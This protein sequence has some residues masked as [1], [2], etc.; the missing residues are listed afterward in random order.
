MNAEKLLET[1]SM[2]NREKGRTIMLLTVLGTSGPWPK[3]GGACSGYLLSHQNRHL[4]L[5]MGSG[6]LSRLQGYAPPESLD[7]IL[8]SHWHFDHAG[9]L[10][11]FVYWQAQSGYRVPVYAPN[12]GSPLSALCAPL[13]VK[14]IAAVRQLGTFDVAVHPAPHLIQTYAVKVR[15]A[16]RTLVYTGD[17]HDIAPL[18]DF[19]AG[20]D[21]L[22]CDAAFSQTV[23]SPKLPHISAAMAGELARHTGG[24]KLVITHFSP[25]ADEIALLK[26]AQS[27]YPDT[28]AACGGLQLMV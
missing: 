19:V 20:A 14:D 25:K 22:V 3:R 21:V 27:V 23:W 7:G 6:V 10:L 24:A 13:Q 8:I 5:D 26:E 15:C 2:K 16:G 11:P 28:V 4:L 17:L 12:D 18:K 1:D 9:D